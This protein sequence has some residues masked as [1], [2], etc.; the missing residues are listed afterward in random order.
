MLF[1]L[2]DELWS[3]CVSLFEDNKRLYDP[4]SDRVG[5]SDHGCLR[6]RLVAHKC[7]FDLAGADTGRADD[8]LQIEGHR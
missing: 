7:W 2:V 6:Y 1:K 8:V 4:P 3:L 5:L